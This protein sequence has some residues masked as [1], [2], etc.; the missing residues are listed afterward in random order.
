MTLSIVCA[1]DAF[2][3]AEEL[4][5][6]CHRQLAGFGELDLR[7]H[8]S[9]WPD[10]P[11]GDVD[12]VREAAGN[13]AEL[14]ALAD[15]ADVLITHLAPI[16][17]AVIGAAPGLRIIGST[18]GGPVNVDL[19]AATAA[20]VPVAFLPGRNLSA[21]AEFAVGLMIAVTRNI[22]AGS[23][24]LADGK[25]DGKYFRYELAGPEIGASTVGLVGFGAIGTHVTRLL[26]A[27]G[28]KVLVYDPYADPA[29]LE[30]S[31]SEIGLAGRVA[32]RRRHRQHAR[33]AD[34]GDNRDG[35]RRLLRPDE[36]RRILRQQCP[37]RIGGDCGPDGGAEQRA[38]GRCGTGRLPSRAATA[39]SPAA[40][41][42]TGGGHAPPG[43]LLPAGRAV[44][45]C[46]GRRAGGALSAVRN[47]GPLRQSGRPDRGRR[48]L[49]ADRSVPGHTV[50]SDPRR[51]SANGAGPGR[52]ARG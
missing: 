39:R 31:G 9:S 47:A 42:G 33:Q 28:A 29:K 48:K 44:L 35:G 36:S 34:P 13:P 17:A 22:G 32:G 46:D 5:A 26:I 19:D 51:L 20:G 11:F 27:F 14:A 23:R 4:A 50:A 10:Q 18:R 1:G 43:G 2:I 45:R 52:P 6:Q 21:A 15:G 41:D 3:T 38:S 40:G 37:R 12:G 25:W 24:A 8:S 16:T 7:L 49:T 30:R